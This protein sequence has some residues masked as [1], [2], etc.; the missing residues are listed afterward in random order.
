MTCDF[1]AMFMNR[2]E[3]ALTDC[4]CSSRR[5]VP[6][7]ALL[8]LENDKVDYFNDSLTL[9]YVF[10][11]RH[12]R[13]G[14]VADILFFKKFMKRVM[15]KSRMSVSIFRLLL[16]MGYEIYHGKFVMVRILHRNSE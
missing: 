3:D 14:H 2:P 12:L 7:R 16:L 11:A 8:Q 1:L 15:G 13:H 9:K 6:D 10:E 5:G 4:F